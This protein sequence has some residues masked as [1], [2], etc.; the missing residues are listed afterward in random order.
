MWYGDRAVEYEC[1]GERLVDAYCQGPQT[2]PEEMRVYAGGQPIGSGKN[3]L[4]VGFVEL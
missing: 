2:Q 3:A 4:V 1:R